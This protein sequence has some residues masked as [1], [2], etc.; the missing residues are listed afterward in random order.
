MRRCLTLRPSNVI[1]PLFVHDGDAV[2]PVGSMPGLFRHTKDSLIEQVGIARDNGVW[3]VALFPNINQELKS[4]DGSEAYN[5]EGLIPRVIRRIKS[6]VPGIKIVT[7]VALD[8]YTTTGQDGV[9]VGDEVVND[10]TVSQL[11]KQARCHIEAGT[12]VIA[13]SDMMDGRIMELRQ[14][15]SEYPNE[16]SLKL[17]SY[18]VKY[19]SAFYG[20][21]RDAL[22][23]APTPGMDKKTY[24]MNPA[25][26]SE[27]NAEAYLDMVEGADI[28][29]VK[30]GLPYL[31]IIS[32]LHTI[33]NN[34]KEIAAYHVSGEYALLKAGVLSHGL[35]ERT[36]VIDVM[37]SFKRAGANYVLTYYATQIAKWVN[38]AGGEIEL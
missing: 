28:L 33:T 25:N 24:Q 17:M 16:N 6:E 14:A 4:V 29:M 1:Q 13:P 11:V 35:D 38:E 23:S 30:P 36:E 19:A 9:V 37:R 5:P 22:G 7:D 27:A 18:A 34:E 26:K 15:I 21:F 2:T 10:L 20:P 31:D 8:P 12:D 3:G 32:Q